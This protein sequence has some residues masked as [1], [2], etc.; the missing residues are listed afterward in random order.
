MLLCIFLHDTIF[1]ELK[2][3]KIKNKS[4][5][6]L[7]FLMR[8]LYIF[9]INTL[10]NINPKTK[11]QRKKAIVHKIFDTKSVIINTPTFTFLFRLLTVGL[12]IYS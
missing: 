11:L 5:F 1:Y 7:L 2:L 6:L 3:D 4:V 9:I 12:Y 8:Q 10:K